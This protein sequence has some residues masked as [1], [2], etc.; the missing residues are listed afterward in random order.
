LR[1]CRVTR[2]WLA[3]CRVQDP[4]PVTARLSK[5]PVHVRLLC[6]YPALRICRHRTRD[7]PVSR[8]RCRGQLCRA[9]CAPALFVS[10][11]ICVAVP[12]AGRATRRAR[13]CSRRQLRRAPRPHGLSPV[14]SMAR[15]PPPPAPA[16]CTRVSGREK[17]G[18]P[19]SGPDT[20]ARADSEPT[21]R[22]AAPRPTT[23]SGRGLQP[24]PRTPAGRP[25]S[26]GPHAG[27]FGHHESVSA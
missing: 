5:R 17:R 13:R 12:G 22:S 26:G 20:A 25:F 15:G 10:L 9:W 2:A 11:R 23:T 7:R 16:P 4:R 3:S 24:P 21:E 8:R 14:A 6:S 27:I 18:W 19:A 1:A